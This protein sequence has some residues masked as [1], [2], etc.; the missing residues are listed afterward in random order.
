M[1]EAVLLKDMQWAVVKGHEF[2]NAF[3]APAMSKSGIMSEFGSLLD[4][5]YPRSRAPSVMMFIRI[6]I[7]YVQQC[8]VYEDLFIALIRPPNLD[9]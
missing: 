1:A 6:K 8:K 3:G 4:L 9:Q 7:H 2:I 5:V